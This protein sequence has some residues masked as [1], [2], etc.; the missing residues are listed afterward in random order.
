MPT[1]SN[2]M[3]GDFSGKPKTVA[4]YAAIESYT[5]SLGTVTKHLTAQAS[6]SVNRK[7]LWAWAYEKT[8]DGS[9]F[10]NVRL[11]RPMEDPHFHRVSQISANRWNHHVVV[12]TMEATESDWLRDLI[13]AGYEFAAS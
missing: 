9:L 5:M 7:F 4:M 6:F 8:A 12:K 10:L 2:K 3:I 11:D 13:H 1:T